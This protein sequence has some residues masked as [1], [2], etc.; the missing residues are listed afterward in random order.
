MTRRPVTRGVLAAAVLFLAGL[1]LSAC[2]TPEQGAERT[3]LNVFAVGDCVAIPST[4]PA[5][6]IAKAAKVD[7]NADPSYTIGATADG[8][9][10]C[11]SDEYQRVSTQYAD[12]STARLCLVPNLL[13]DHCYVLEMPIGVVQKADCAER[14]QEQGLLVQITQRLDTRDQSAC[15]KATGSYAWP[16]PSPARTYCTQTLF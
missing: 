16:Y 6:P 7:C 4:S 8:T 2:G 13:A 1:V 12:P 5:D 14:G 15:P 3:A 10:T 9:G 11:P